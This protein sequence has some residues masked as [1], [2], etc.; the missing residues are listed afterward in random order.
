M[1]DVLY[2]D[3][4]K[5]KSYVLDGNW[6]K[7]FFGNNIEKLFTHSQSNL[8]EMEREYTVWRLFLLE[9][10]YKQFFMKWIK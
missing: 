4:D 10:W 5:V 8:L 3:I 9:V 1:H 2:Q 7:K 6:G